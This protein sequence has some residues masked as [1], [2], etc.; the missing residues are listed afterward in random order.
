MP[1][2]NVLRVVIQ[3][4]MPPGAREVMHCHRESK[5]LFYVL[6]SVLTMRTELK[7]VTIP[8]GQ[9][10]VVEPPTPHQASNEISQACRFSCGAS[11]PS[12]GDR[13]DAD[14]GLLVNP[15]KWRLHQSSHF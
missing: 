14:D 6:G 9:A 11:P 13:F 3:E 4:R 1:E 7:S 12:H 15:D 5:Q 10:A 2:R 8:V